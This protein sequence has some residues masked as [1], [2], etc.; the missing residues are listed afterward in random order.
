M[1]AV[2][3]EAKEEQE[4]E[5]RAFEEEQQGDVTLKS[6]KLD[7][8]SNVV[9]NDVTKSRVD[10]KPNRQSRKASNASSSAKGDKILVPGSTVRVVSGAFADFVGTTKKWN[11]KTGKVCCLCW[12]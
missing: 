2:F 11:R 10:T 7:L 5:N 1:E 4:R 12:F 6:Y 3:H 9:S 8:E